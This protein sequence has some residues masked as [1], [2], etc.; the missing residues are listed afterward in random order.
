[1]Y[2]FITYIHTW[3][4]DQL[5][6]LILSFTAE[7]TVE[8]ILPFTISIIFEL[9]H[10]MTSFGTTSSKGLNYPKQINQQIQTREHLLGS[11]IVLLFKVGCR[12]S[13]FG[14]GSPYL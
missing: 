12:F 9:K 2:A 1:M 5:L 10:H 6:D 4:G 11:L 7:G 13:S 3:T 14:I 8:I